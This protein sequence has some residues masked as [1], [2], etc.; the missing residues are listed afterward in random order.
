MAY[1][2]K[3]RNVFWVWAQI[4]CEYIL[5]KSKN[6]NYCFKVNFVTLVKT[7]VV[8]AKKYRANSKLSLSLKEKY[9]NG[10]QGQCLY[11]YAKNILLLP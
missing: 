1:T 2:C 9:V 5:S 7:K 8:S 3:I 4:S 6:S 11:I 10:I